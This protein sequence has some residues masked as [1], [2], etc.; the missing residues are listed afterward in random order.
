MWHAL[1]GLARTAPTYDPRGC[2]PALVMLPFPASAWSP[3]PYFA[4]NRPSA[5]LR[6]PLE[7]R[8]SS[9]TAGDRVHRLKTLESVLSIEVVTG[10]IP[11]LVSLSAQ[12]SVNTTA[13][14]LGFLTCRLVLSYGLNGLLGEFSENLDLQNMVGF[15]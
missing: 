12:E 10:W 15:Q 13:L 6:P 8:V 14:S 1:R 7:S 9:S 4:S 3:L 2:P 11:F 5:L